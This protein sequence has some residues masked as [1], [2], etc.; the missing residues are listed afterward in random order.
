MATDTTPPPVVERAY[1]VALATEEERT[2]APTSATAERDEMNTFTVP[3]LTSYTDADARSVWRSAIHGLII[4]WQRA[5]QPRDAVSVDAIEQVQGVIRIMSNYTSDPNEDSLVESLAGAVAELVAHIADADANPVTVV[6][7][8]LAAPDAP[9]DVHAEC[10]ERAERIEERM[11]KAEAPITDASDHRLSPIW[12]RAHEIADERG[13]CETFDEMMESLG[14]PSREIDVT[15]TV[16]GT[17]SA[18]VAVSDLNNDWR[19][20]GGEVMDCCSVDWE[21]TSYDRD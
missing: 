6:T 2:S 3:L 17:F 9:A 12:E 4:D 10:I 7:P 15:F 18:R 14:A 8:T 1:A 16:T 5:G 19:D 13:H 20:A 21:I 11:R